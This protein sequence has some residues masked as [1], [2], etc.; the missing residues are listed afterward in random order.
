MKRILVILGHPARESFG[1]ALAKAY[2]KG[3]R[4]AGAEVRELSLRDMRFDMNLRE[5]YNAK[6]PLEPD[7]LAAQEAL[8]WAEHLVFVYPIWW[9]GPPALLKG[10][11]DR[12][13]LPD[14]AYRFRPNSPMCDGLLAGRSA[15]LLV[16]M[17]TPPWYFKWIYRAPGHH[18]MKRTILGFC[19][20]K[21]VR[22][23]DVGPVKG[24][25][26]KQRERRVAQCHELGRKMA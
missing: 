10:F 22:I 5:G 13:F 21:P 2:A 4:D 11:I 1:E 16:T 18:Q 24:T 14:F 23:T 6:Q 7:L 15:R 12:L 25:S 20:V 3:A 9:G 8:I 17:D 26:Q 19:G